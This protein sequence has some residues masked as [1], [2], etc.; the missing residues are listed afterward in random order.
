MRKEYNFSKSKKNTYLKKLKKP[1]T[2]RVDIDTIGYFKGLSDQ[3]GIPYQNLINLYLAECA[4]KNK[5][6]D[7]SW[8]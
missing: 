4:S 2:I 3:T 6:I 1:I 5:K 8:K 7:L